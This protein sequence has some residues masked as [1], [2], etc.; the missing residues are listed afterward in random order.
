MLVDVGM[1]CGYAWLVWGH[2][3][4]NRLAVAWAFPT[5]PFLPGRLQ[6]G[7]Y[8]QSVSLAFPA[9]TM[10]GT[11]G[12]QQVVAYADGKCCCPQKSSLAPLRPPC[13][14]LVAFEYAS[15]VSIC[16]LAGF[17]G[18]MLLVVVLLLLVPATPL[19]AGC[20]GAAQPAQLS[21]WAF[22]VNVQITPPAGLLHSTP[23]Q[24]CLSL[25]PLAA[26][27]YS[28]LVVKYCNESQWVQFNGTAYNN[29][30]S[31]INLGIWPW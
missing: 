15:G 9:I 28:Q 6:F 30:V 3:N 8:V 11:M 24:P 19:D 22:S 18:L 4:H 13:S 20:P 16:Q 26:S 23:A 12:P 2:G 21:A 25:V 1:L 14:Q 17:L 5:F 7:S 29:P 31:N 27:N 10:Y